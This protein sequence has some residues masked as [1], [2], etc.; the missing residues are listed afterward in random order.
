MTF[1]L[2]WYVVYVKT[3]L[4]LV[5]HGTFSSYKV[6]TSLD[7]ACHV[8][9]IHRKI[10]TVVYILGHVAQ[11]SEKLVTLRTCAVLQGTRIL[12]QHQDNAT[13][14]HNAVTLHDTATDCPQTKHMS[15]WKCSK[16]H[17]VKLLTTNQEPGLR[18]CPMVQRRV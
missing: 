17:E 13:G 14:D 18:F 7:D 8:P 5:E 6:L 10:W 1:T 3:S 4:S 15:S 2:L 9:I 12:S 16:L 11:L